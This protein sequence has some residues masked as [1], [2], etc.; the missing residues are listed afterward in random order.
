MHSKID[1]REVDS[2]GPKGDQRLELWLHTTLFAVKLERRLMEETT[3]DFP[4]TDNN[5]GFV[6]LS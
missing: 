3:P 5:L 6:F 4:S 2:S 1:V